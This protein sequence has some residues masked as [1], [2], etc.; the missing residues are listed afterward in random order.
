MR[1]YACH[2]AKTSSESLLRAAAPYD[3]WQ[4]GPLRQSRVTRTKLLGPAR[5]VSIESTNRHELIAGLNTSRGGGALRN[6]LS[7]V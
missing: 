2:E 1:V 5:I 7:D 4:L 3:D 6:Y